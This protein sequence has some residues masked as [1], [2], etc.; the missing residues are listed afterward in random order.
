MN[1]MRYIG[2]F[3]FLSGIISLNVTV[4]KAFFT[5]KV[6]IGH[7]FFTISNCSLRRICYIQHFFDGIHSGSP[8]PKAGL[9]RWNCVFSNNLHM[10]FNSVIDLMP[11]T[12]LPPSQV[13]V[14]TVIHLTWLIL[15]LALFLLLILV[16]LSSYRLAPVP[17]QFS[18]Y[19]M[20]WLVLPSRIYQ[21]SQPLGLLWKHPFF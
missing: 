19:Y 8:R 17:Y 21:L 16:S 15:I 7:H 10:E 1:L 14:S 3:F 11:M 18:F 6:I 2:I 12:N 5:S 4:L 9:I 20:L 13:W